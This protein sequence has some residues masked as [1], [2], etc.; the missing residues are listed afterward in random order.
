M[1]LTPPNP[2][3]QLSLTES[4]LMTTSILI[5]SPCEQRQLAEQ[6]KHIISNSFLFLH[7][8][9]KLMIRVRSCLLP[10]LLCHFYLSLFFQCAPISLSPLKQMALIFLCLFLF[11]FLFSFSLRS[12]VSTQ[13]H[14]STE[15]K[16]VTTE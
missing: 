10:L 15:E 6:V 4:R 5:A 3:H 9:Q 7:T 1:Y 16:W 13:S 14:S 11:L 12:L 8:E 2:H